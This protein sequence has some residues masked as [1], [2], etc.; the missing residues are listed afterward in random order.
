MG[1]GARVRDRRSLSF[2][3]EFAPLR[4]RDLAAALQTGEEHDGGFS[5]IE[6]DMCASRLAVRVPRA[7]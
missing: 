3:V 2:E 6:P 1:R 5:T 4:E 7:V